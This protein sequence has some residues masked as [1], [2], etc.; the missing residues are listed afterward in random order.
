MYAFNVYY[1]RKLSSFTHSA[2]FSMQK[3]PLGCEVHDSRTNR[4]IIIAISKC[5][6]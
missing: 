5:N 2:Q 6:T 1:V 4:A 3:R